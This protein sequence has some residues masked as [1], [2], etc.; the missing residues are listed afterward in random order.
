MRNFIA[1]FGLVSLFPVHCAAQ[2]NSAVA[3]QTYT[4]KATPKTVA[5]A[6]MMPPLLPC[7]A[8]ILETPSSLKL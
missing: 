2:A 8:S 5:W 6:T 7:S 4:L 3:P 1:L